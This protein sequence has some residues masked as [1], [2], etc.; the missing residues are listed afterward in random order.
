MKSRGSLQSVDGAARWRRSRV[1]AQM[2]FPVSDLPPELLVPPPR[3]W[4]DCPYRTKEGTLLKTSLVMIAVFPAFLGVRYAVENLTFEVQAVLVVAA[5][6]A[7]AVALLTLALWRRSVRKARIFERGGVVPGS[8]SVVRGPQELFFLY[9][10]SVEIDFAA[11]GKQWAG[12]VAYYTLKKVRLREGAPVH[13]LVTT[14]GGPFGVYMVGQGVLLGERV[15]LTR[16]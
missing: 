2:P 8:I 14:P 13:V 11:F 1:G 15:W 16:T 9:V 7:G 12:I 4:E 10:G 3:K 5:V 6:G